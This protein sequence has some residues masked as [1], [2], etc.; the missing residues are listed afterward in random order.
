MVVEECPVLM[1]VIGHYYNL[2]QKKPD[3]Y[4]R[5][6]IWL[7]SINHQPPQP[8]VMDQQTGWLINSFDFCQPITDVYCAKVDSIGGCRIQNS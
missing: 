5:M 1:P 2:V 6:V 4:A 3:I 7:T 8:Q